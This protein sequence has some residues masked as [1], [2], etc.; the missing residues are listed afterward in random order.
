M[1]MYRLVTK[2][3]R[4]KS[5]LK[6]L[7]KYKFFNIESETKLAFTKLTEIQEEFHNHPL[8]VELQKIEKL[9]MHEYNRLN[10]SI[11][12]FLRQK[13]KSEWLKGGD[14]NT[15]YFHACLRKRKLYN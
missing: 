10:K 4:L 8:N 2:L 1:P 15:T 5:I 7:N 9:A 6:Q 14:E 13:V 12:C 3:K 11:M